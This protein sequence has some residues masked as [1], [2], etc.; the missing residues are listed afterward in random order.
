MTAPILEN[1]WEPRGRSDR[2]APFGAILVSPVISLLL[3]LAL[4]AGQALAQ[5]YVVQVSS[6]ST[7]A[8]AKSE[9][10]RL[11]N[12]GIPSF[13]RAEEIPGRGIANR[14]YLGPFNTKE[15]ATAAAQ[16]LKSSGHVKDFIVKSDTAQLQAPA[17]APYQGQAYPPQA[18][19]PQDPYQGQAY[20]PQDPYQQQAYPPQNPY[21]QQADPYQQQAYPP[22]Q[23]PYQGQGALPPPPLSGN[24]APPQSP[25]TPVNPLSPDIPVLGTPPPS[26][27]AVPTLNTPGGAYAPPPMVGPGGERMNP[28]LT[29]VQPQPQGT[30]PDTSWPPGSGAAQTPPPAA[31]APSADTQWPP[32]SSDTQWPPPGY[33]PPQS[34]Q[35]QAPNRV[36]MPGETV[37]FDESGRPLPQAPGGQ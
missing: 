30:S 20:P 37:W 10:Q 36:I 34:A 31:A 19:P 12:L 23:N 3:T 15:E 18:Y 9:T 8:A 33:A 14:V 28:Q 17:Q 26:Q 2:R 25:P 4:G 6:V 5:G 1:T 11:L 13:Q 7:E 32:P 29:Q 16:A 27:P 21:Q 35:P 24:Q 22:A